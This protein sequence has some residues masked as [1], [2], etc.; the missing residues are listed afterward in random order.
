[1]ALCEHNRSPDI[2]VSLLDRKPNAG[3]ISNLVFHKIWQLVSDD[4]PT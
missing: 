1:M 3:P 2:T 4:K